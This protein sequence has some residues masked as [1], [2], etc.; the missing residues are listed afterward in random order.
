MNQEFIWDQKGELHMMSDDSDEKFLIIPLNESDPTLGYLNPAHYPSD[1]RA[2][3]EI[4][5]MIN[6]DKWLCTTVYDIKTQKYLLVDKPVI[7][8][9]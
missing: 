6:E 5:I 2:R 3:V 8:L 7:R 4:S 9:K 1:R